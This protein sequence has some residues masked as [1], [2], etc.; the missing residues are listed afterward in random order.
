VCSNAIP[1]GDWAL[2]DIRPL[3]T[4]VVITGFIDKNTL[5]KSGKKWFEV[6]GCWGTNEVFP[7]E[8]GGNASL[9]SDGRYWGTPRTFKNVEQEEKDSKNAN[10]ALCSITTVIGGVTVPTVCSTVKNVQGGARL[11][12]FFPYIGNGKYD[13]MGGL[14]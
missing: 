13:P 3:S 7:L 12:T 8:G 5:K 2:W 9:K 10:K 1:F 14:Y 11:T 4:G 6:R